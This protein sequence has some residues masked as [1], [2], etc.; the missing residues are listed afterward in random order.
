MTINVRANPATLTWSNFREVDSIPDADADGEQ[1]EINPEMSFPQSLQPQKQNGVFRLPDFT[2]TVAPNALNTMVLKT[3]DKTA[4]LLQHEQGHYNLLILVA[5]AMSRELQTATGT[6][7][8]DLG[9]QLQ[10][11]RNTHKTRAETIDSAYDTKTD[12]GRNVDE[13]QR[14]NALITAAL[15][16]PAAGDI[17][18]MSL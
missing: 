2:V 10:Q 11:V 18:G 1:A 12:H 5:R 4:A 6:S 15:A 14:W 7:A 16:N 9:N 3:A 17:D 8:Q 13:Q